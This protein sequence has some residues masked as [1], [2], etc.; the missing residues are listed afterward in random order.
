A[1]SQLSEDGLLPRSLARRNRYDTPWVATVV[2]AGMSAA[3]LAFGDPPSI[4][5]AANFTYLIGISLPS[6]AVWLLR[7]HAPHLRRPWRAPKVTIMLGVL[8]A[9]GWAVTTVFG[10]EQFCLRYVLFGLA[11]AY[12]GSLAY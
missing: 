1:L 8:A 11:L 5:A 9:C 4:I 10:F 6:V 7:R 2:T 3:F 12:S